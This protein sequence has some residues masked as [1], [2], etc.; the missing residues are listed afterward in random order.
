ME[1]CPSQHSPILF[2]IAM[3]LHRHGD[4]EDLLGT[5]AHAVQDAVGVEGAS[6]IL[7]DDAQREFYF[8]VTAFDDRAA[9]NRM[10]EVRY[11]ADRGIAG[12]VYR[13]GRPLVVQDTYAS[14]YFLK[15]VDEKVGFHT[16]SMLDVPI[17]T[18]ERMIGVLCAVNKKRGVFVHED[19]D[20]MSAIAGMVAMP[21][22]NARMADAL[23]RSLDD[24]RRLNASRMHAIHRVSHEIKTPVSVLAGS[25]ALLRRTLGDAMTPDIERILA[26][27][28]RN[29][30]RLLSVQYAI[31]DILMETDETAP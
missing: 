9:G 31:E 20:L 2:E 23:R 5:I 15:S 14:P 24:V 7:L 18:A 11:P 30:N 26:R 29:L 19:V 8:R 21:I 17:R 4:L 10:K 12:H 22:E 3:A 28:E 16:R 6:V 1:P 25:V 13:T 27:S